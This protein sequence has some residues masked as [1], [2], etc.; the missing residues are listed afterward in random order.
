MNLMQL[1]LTV[2]AALFILGHEAANAG[3]TVDVAGAIACVNAAHS[4][5]VI[6]WKWTAMAKAATWASLSDPSVVPIG[7]PLNDPGPPPQ[8]APR[9]SHRPR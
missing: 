2:P 7:M 6:P 9:L 4:P 1:S 3:Q 5:Q 8:A